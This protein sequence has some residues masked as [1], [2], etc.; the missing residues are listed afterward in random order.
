MKILLLS[1][2]F[3]SSCFSQLAW[4]D[5]VTQRL[6]RALNAFDSLQAEFKQ[7]VLDDNKQVVQ[8]SMGQVSIQRPGKF[9]WIYRQPYEQQ[10]IADGKETG[11]GSPVYISESDI[12]NV[13]TAKA[14]ISSRETRCGQ[15]STLRSGWTDPLS[16]GLLMR[17]H[18]VRFHRLRDGQ[19]LE[20]IGNELLQVVG[21]G[22]VEELVP[23]EPVPRPGQEVKDQVEPGDEPDP[24]GY[25][26]AFGG[27]EA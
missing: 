24:Q 14:A 27:V 19:V 6:N 4:A 12:E 15:V 3:I 25:R 9:A 23:V 10:I 5:E 21:H 26:P 16:D 8:Q 2:L 7:T 22:E 17:R 20:R 18:G 11:T 1:V 13:I